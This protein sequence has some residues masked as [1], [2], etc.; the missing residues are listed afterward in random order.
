M[1]PGQA[2][3]QVLAELMRLRRCC[4]NPRLVVPTCGLTG[5]KLEAFA[6]LVD[7]L[8]ENQHKALVFCQFVDHLSLLREHLDKQG[9]HY[10]YLDGS[11][12]PKTRQK[13]ID[14]FQ[15]GE[16]DLF[17]ISLKAG[18]TGSEPDG[19]RLRDPPRPLV[20]PGGRGPGHRPRPPHRPDPPGDDLPPASPPTRSRR[21]S[22]SSTT[23]SATWPTPSWRA[24]TPPTLSA[25]TS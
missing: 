16:G 18:G 23:P 22:S 15:N 7:E 14:A 2:H 10:Q 24:P 1:A 6:E 9:I 5:S 12:P 4:C 21:R 11:T 25:P 13:R 20:E 19:R 17:L 8:L 3:I